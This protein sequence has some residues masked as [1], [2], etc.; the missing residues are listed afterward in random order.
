MDPHKFNKLLCKIKDDKR[1]LIPIY[2]EFHSKIIIHIRCR[3]G[4]RVCAEDVVQEVYAALLEIKE[5][6]FIDSPQQWLFAMADHKAADSFRAQCKETSYSDDLKAPPVC[7]I[8]TQ[9]IA[10]RLALEQIDPISQKILLM[11]FWEGYSHEE[12]AKELN[13]SCG[14]VRLKAS[15]A[16]KIL[17]DLL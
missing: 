5:H 8:P 13:M 1:A 15:R 16:Y 6:A 4:Q 2:K 10:I 12:I 17:K 3:Y 14:N 9:S 11:H 7:E